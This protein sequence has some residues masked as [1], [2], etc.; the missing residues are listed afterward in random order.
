MNV[1]DG[2]AEALT[3]PD[4]FTL[5]IQISGMGLRDLALSYP[6]IF[7]ITE[8]E[9]IETPQ[10]TARELKKALLQ[11]DVVAPDDGAPTVCVI[12][13]G[14]QEEHP[15]LEPGIDKD[16]S[17]CFLPGI[18]ITD[19][20]DRVR[21][22]GH[23]SRVAGAV[24]H[25]ESVPSAG[26]VQ[27]ETW[28]QNARVLN[29]DCG[30]PKEMFPP[31]VLRSV[32]DKYH[33][34]P[35]QTRIF[36]HSINSN[37]PCR[38][39]HMSAWAAEIDLLCTEHDILVIQSSG[40]LRPSRPAPQPGVAEQISA[41]KPYPEYLSENS[42]RVANPGHSLQAL[43]VGSVAYGEIQTEGWR[44]LASENGQ[45]SAFSR[46]GLGIWDSIKPEVVEYGG[47]YL[48]TQNNPPDVDCPM[49]GRAAYPE[50]VR[51]TFHGGPA[52]D[53]DE[54]GTSFAAPKVARIAAKLQAVLPDEPCLL[55]RALIVQSAQWP[56]WTANLSRDDRAQVLRRLGYGIPDLER[57]TT[58]TDHRTTFITHKE[59]SLGPGDCHIYQVPIPGGLRRPGDDFDVRIDVTLSYAAS[60]RRTRRAPRGYLAVW[61][62]WIS[63][64]RGETFEAFLTRA[65]KSEDDPT[66]EG[67]GSL[68]WTIESRGNWGQIPN[69]RRNVGTVQ[70]D[71][72]FV[73]SN[74]LPED[75]CIAVR[76]H[77]G[78]SRDSESVAAY[79]LAVTFELVGAEIPIYEPLRTAVLELESQVESD[80]EAELELQT[81]S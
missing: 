21:P 79:T 77:Q 57:V 76:G 39:R 50:L 4:S 48:V 52:F 64:R 75:F 8:P 43:T 67:S 2:D 22:S 9:E 3:L 27:L 16:T 20:A 80:V 47:D 51:S 36:N 78:W 15:W 73:K 61:L 56:Q 74:A 81:E 26:V 29:D 7:E 24:L 66:D 30:M 37:V 25:G 70:K 55:Y 71:W 5:R 6:Y 14:I 11:L 69:V 41:G 49:I 23:G 72:A 13:S 12:D 31:A 62:D 35:R 17:H 28:V 10:S 32:V 40:N 60:P 65:M 53:R 1:D 45:P 54:V 42:S 44:S 59:R 58:N 34:G 68:G 46:A 18:P 38:M 19:I 63:N 33:R